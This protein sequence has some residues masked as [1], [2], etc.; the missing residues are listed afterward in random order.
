MNISV[1]IPAYNEEALI[2]KTIESVRR[3]A[4][5]ETS[6]E[7]IVAD[8]QSDDKTIKKAKKAGAIIVPVAKRQ[9]SVQLNKGAQA[10]KGSILYFLHADTQP[11]LHFDQH[12][13]QRIK[14]G[15]KAGCFRLSFDR[16]HILLR[17]YAW[18]TQ[19]DLDA[20]RYG[21]QS[22]FIQKESFNN[23]GGFREDHRYFED[24]EIVKRIKKEEDSFDILRSRVVTSSRKYSQNGIVKLQ[25]I[26]IF[27]YVLYKVGI[28]QA[29]LGQ[30]YRE[31][32]H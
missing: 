5:D 12:I 22:L 19:F 23:I 3:R 18:F 25:A 7:I 4:F 13:T 21:D 28:N 31:L 29:I 14:E 20:F 26:F 17:F 6:L 30:I 11:P 8:G 10:A 24:Y 1:I 27:M 32:V 15:S 9:R 16:E 2:A